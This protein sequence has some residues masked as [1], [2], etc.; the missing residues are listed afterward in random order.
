MDESKVILSQVKVAVSRADLSC[1]HEENSKKRAV[2]VSQS[3]PHYLLLELVQVIVDVLDH[4]IRIDET[5][6]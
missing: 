5:R 1:G 2:S 6:L 4:V 3:A